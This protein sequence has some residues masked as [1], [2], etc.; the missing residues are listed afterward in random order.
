VTTVWSARLLQDTVRRHFGGERVIVVS[1][2][3]PCVHDF[4]PDDSIVERHPVSGLVTALDPV[5]RATGGTWVAHGSGTAD[6]GMVDACDRV[7]IDGGEGSYTLRRVWLSRG[8]ERGY[9]HGFSNSALRPLCHVAFEPPRFT[10]NDWRH[11]GAVNC[12][13]AD[14]V[15][16][17]ADSARP[18][19]LVQDYHLALLP[20]LLRERRP[21]ATI[22]AFWHIPWP[23]VA[24]LSRLP[25]RDAIVEGLLGSDIVGFQTPEHAR[26]FM[27]SV[28]YL[29]DAAV[30][31][32]SGLIGR[33]HGTV[34]VRAY[35]MSVEWP[36]RWTASAPSIAECR[37]TVRAELGIEPD[38]P[39]MISVD[40]LDYTKG[41]EERLNAIRR[42]LGRGNAT[43]GRPVFVQIA[44]PSPTRLGQ[45]RG[46]GDRVRAQVAELNARFG[47]DDYRP[48]ILIER[49]DEPADV[50]RFYR[51]GDAC[52]VNSLDDGMNLV[53][54]EFVA[55]R[56]DGQGVLVLS[57]FAGAALELTDAFLVNP[58]H[59]DDV[60]DGIADALTLPPDDQARR[61][62][63]MRRQVADHNVYR[64]AGRILLDAAGVRRHWADAVTATG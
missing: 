44:A 49:H 1:N 22:V 56:D 42:L 61:M 21:D 52:H 29:P 8:E 3:E 19:I 62:R 50:F 7:R 64:W 27:E 59:V 14:V 15:S 57:Q 12:R 45:Y 32:K 5:L 10:R 11:Y 36:N 43:V 39:L 37:R 54:K 30:D 60:A 63:S 9:Y 46:V 4:A 23:N 13:F 51:A 25:Y 41:I 58:Y 2:R 55:A 17:E 16:R 6:R 28:E 20:N 48:V 26:N 33:A 38:A 40:R 35:P 24:R 18:V 47:S 34:A 31:R 53:A